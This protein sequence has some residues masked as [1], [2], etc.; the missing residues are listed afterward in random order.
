MFDYLCRT[1]EKYFREENFFSLNE[2]RSESVIDFG[3]KFHALKLLI[4]PFYKTIVSKEMLEL[5]FYDVEFSV[6]IFWFP[7]RL[8]YNNAVPWTLVDWFAGFMC[9]VLLSPF[10]MAFGAINLC[11]N[12]SVLCLS[13]ITRTVA[14]IW[15]MLIYA[16]SGENA[17]THG[18]NTVLITDKSTQANGSLYK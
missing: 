14:T 11:F 5:I 15:H 3:I 9:G 6:A 12:L 2:Y 8:A 10:I 13:L 16:F 18:S 1:E 7:V 17:S 4:L